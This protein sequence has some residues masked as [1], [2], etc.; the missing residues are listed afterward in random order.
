MPYENEISDKIEL[1]NKLSH[2]NIGKGAIE[3]SQTLLP[4]E[5]PGNKPHKVGLDSGSHQH[6][7]APLEKSPVHEHH[8]PPAIQKEQTAGGSQRHNHAEMS[9]SSAFGGP[10]KVM[11]ALGSGTSL[12]PSDTPAYMLHSN[13]GGWSVMAH[14]D[15]RAGIN[16]Q[17]GPRGVTRP[18]SLN[19]GMVMAERKLGPGFLMLRGM[20]SMEPFTIPGAGS[21]ML[22]QTGETYQ[23]KLIVDAQHQ[24]NLVMELAAGYSLPLSKDV[25]VFAYGGPVF[26]PAL[27]PPAFMHRESAMGVPLSH[28]WQ[29]ATHITNGGVTLGADIGRLRIEGSGFHGKEPGEDRLAVRPGNF[30]SWSAR[31][32]FAPTSNWLIQ[33]SHGHL[34]NPE[35]HEPGDVARTTASVMYNKRWQDGNWATTGV[36]GRNDTAS[37]GSNS[38][39][40]ETNLN[41]LD[42]NYIWARFES[43]AKHGLGAENIFGKPGFVHHDDNNHDQAHES[44]RV[45]AF[46]LGVGRD[47]WKTN[48]FRFGVGGEVT[49]Y[50]T[51]DHL[52]SVYGETPVGFKFFLRFR[53]DKM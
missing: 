7:Q 44:A 39:L 45:N 6:K 48:D 47:V 17:T 29:D 52:N 13:N 33:V 24:H 41:Y 30:D 3:L 21:P 50:D 46:T 9:M 34:K 53:P 40:L 2:S 14:G 27:G 1:P 19:W 38:Y 11:N 36:F 35:A 31:A 49:M 8:A 15:I 4:K 22:F 32:T 23:G 42:K 43:A 20:F 28:H 12:L 25:S 10:D 18:E 37:G 26:E 5:P 51:P 16:S